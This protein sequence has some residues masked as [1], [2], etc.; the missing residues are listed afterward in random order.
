MFLTAVAGSAATWGCLALAQGAPVKGGVTLLVPFLPGGSSDMVA[1][2]LAAKFQ[3]KLGQPVVVTHAAGAGGDIAAAQLNPTVV[4]AERVRGDGGMRLRRLGD[5]GANTTMPASA[6][7]QAIE[8]RPEQAGAV[9]LLEQS[10]ATVPAG[11]EGL[12]RRGSLPF[13][14]PFFDIE[15]DCVRTHHAQTRMSQQCQ[16]DVAVPTIP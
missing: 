3:E 16:R 8:A 1:R 4:V 10:M 13:G 14:P 7:A 2:T 6:A 9:V 15:F 12:Q 5:A 11:L